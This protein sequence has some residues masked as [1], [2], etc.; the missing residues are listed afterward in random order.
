[1]KKQTVK[2]FFEFLEKREK[3]IPPFLYKL[4]LSPETLTEEELT[5]E[6]DLDLWG[7]D[8][9]RLPE[10]LKV[11]GSLGLEDSIIEDLPEGLEVGGSIHLMNTASLKR[12]P[13]NLTVGRSLHIDF[14]YFE[15]VP[16]NLKIKGNLHARNSKLIRKYG[17]DLRKEIEIK[18]GYVKGWIWGWEEEDYI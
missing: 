17:K 6:G 8:I 4:I 12:L 13:D 15:D 5:V 16:V 14:T 3:A 2:Q 1:M 7:I 11:K 9:K 10:G 18:G